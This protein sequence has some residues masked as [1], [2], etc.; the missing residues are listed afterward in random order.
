MSVHV[1]SCES[2]VDPSVDV[3]HGCVILARRTGYMH[4]PQSLGAM[5]E[6]NVHSAGEDGNTFNAKIREVFKLKRYNLSVVA[7]QN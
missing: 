6:P 2:H 7:I 5:F 3:L 1:K 4:E